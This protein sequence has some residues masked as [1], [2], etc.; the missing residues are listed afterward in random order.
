MVCWL[1]AKHPERLD[2][3]HLND[4]IMAQLQGSGHIP[5]PDLELLG[6]TEEMLG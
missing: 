2:N 6:W 5:G 3:V 4:A 1:D